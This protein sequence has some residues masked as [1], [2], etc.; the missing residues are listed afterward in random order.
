MCERL[1]QLLR[2]IRVGAMMQEAQTIR[3]WESGEERDDFAMRLLREANLQQTLGN[4]R[5]DEHHRILSTLS[6]VL[7]D[8]AA[9]ADE[10]PPADPL[11]R[12]PETS[13]SPHAQET[14]CFLGCEACEGGR[15]RKA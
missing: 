13:S 12:V 14:S 8:D 7:P 9:G 11:E 4:L 15:M 6:F 10:G 3:D 1:G 2:C 5:Q